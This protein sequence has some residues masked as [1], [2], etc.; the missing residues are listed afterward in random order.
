MTFLWLAYSLLNFDLLESHIAQFH[1][2]LKKVIP[3]FLRYLSLSEFDA[4]SW[5][6]GNEFAPISDT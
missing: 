5:K 2:G 6:C 4:P 3:L 1:I